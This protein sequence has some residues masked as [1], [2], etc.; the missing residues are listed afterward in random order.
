MNGDDSNGNDKYERKGMSK[1]ENGNDN[2]TENRRKNN[3]DTNESENSAEDNNDN[4]KRIRVLIN[5]HKG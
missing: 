3:E 2:K 4:E 5:N 1:P